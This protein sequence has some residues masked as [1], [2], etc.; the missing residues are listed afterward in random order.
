ME[1]VSLL[2]RNCRRDT[3]GDCALAMKLSNQTRSE[4]NCLQIE[5]FNMTASVIKIKHFVQ[6]KKNSYPKSSG[7]KVPCASLKSRDTKKVNH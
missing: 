4:S 6:E 7:Y 5:S 1:K 2:D 3:R